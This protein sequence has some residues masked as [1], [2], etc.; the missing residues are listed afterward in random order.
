[1]WHCRLSGQLHFRNGTK[2]LPAGFRAWCWVIPGPRL[3][4]PTAAFQDVDA[5]REGMLT[6]RV[7]ENWV[8]TGDPAR[9]FHR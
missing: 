3:C 4:A 8:Q 9:E 5:Q 6:L 7:I 2:R 1:M